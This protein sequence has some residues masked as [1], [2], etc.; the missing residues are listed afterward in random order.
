M[1]TDEYESTASGGPADQSSATPADGST[2]A[3]A[4]HT[5]VGMAIANEDGARFGA[6]GDHVDGALLA[7]LVGAAVDGC[8]ACQHGPLAD[9]ARDPLTL[10]RLVELSGIAMQGIA[11]GIPDAMTTANDEAST[12]GAD[13]RAM[14]RAGLNTEDHSP[15]YAAAVALDHG[16]RRVLAEDALDMLTGALTM[17]A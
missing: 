14:L 17:G 16:R 4:E 13:Y 15:M 10:T 7:R 9:L 2:D 8:P 5:H 3:P 12:L 1:P 6:P 11:G